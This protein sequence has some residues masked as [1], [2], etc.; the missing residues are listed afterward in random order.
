MKMEIEIPEECINYLGKRVMD[1][2]QYRGFTI[3]EW[4]NKILNDEP[5]ADIEPVKRGKWIKGKHWD[6]WFCSVCRNRAYLDQKENPILSYYCPHCGVR[7]CIGHDRVDDDGAELP[8]QKGVKFMPSIDKI[9]IKDLWICHHKEKP[10]NNVLCLVLIF[11]S[12]PFMGDDYQIRVMTYDS[13]GNIYTDVI[14]GLKMN[15]DS[16]VCTYWRYAR[17]MEESDPALKA[18]NV[19]E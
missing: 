8:T 2:Y 18:E 3:R 16:P 4:A 14:N 11:E 7:N 17:L 1:E 19:K 12:L 6:E 15:V 13:V 10:K 9:N 5:T